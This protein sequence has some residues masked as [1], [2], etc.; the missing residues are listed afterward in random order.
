MSSEKMIFRIIPGLPIKRNSL[1]SLR[2]HEG[3][4]FWSQSS[5]TAQQMMVKVQRMGIWDHCI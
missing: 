2:N 1:E 5:L 4:R 3:P